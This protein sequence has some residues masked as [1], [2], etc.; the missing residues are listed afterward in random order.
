MHPDELPMIQ[1]AF[2]DAMQ[3]SAASGCAV[4]IGFT[5]RLLLPDGSWT[6]VHTAGCIEARALA[7]RWLLGGALAAWRRAGTR[8]HAADMCACD[9]RC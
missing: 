3:R 4:P 6:W 5:R 1:A 9:A 7:A 2:A 8:H